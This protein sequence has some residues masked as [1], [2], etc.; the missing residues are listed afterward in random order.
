MSTRWLTSIASV[1]ARNVNRHW[2]ILIYHMKWIVQTVLLVFVS[3]HNT[4]TLCGGV[5][6]V[7]ALCIALTLGLRPFRHK[8]HQALNL[9]L[10]LLFCAVVALLI[11]LKVSRR[12]YHVHVQAR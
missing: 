5:L 4:R 11:T 9:L 3:G 10:S 8:R 12:S 7:E 2:W 1:P 6:G